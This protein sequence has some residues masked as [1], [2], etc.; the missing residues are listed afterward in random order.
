MLLKLNNCQWCVSIVHMCSPADCWRLI[1]R[2]CKQPLLLTHGWSRLELPELQKSVF[3]Y[4][5]PAVVL[6]L[7]H[8]NTY[9]E[10]GKCPG[11][12]HSLW[13]ETGPGGWARPPPFWVSWSQMI[14]PNYGINET[15]RLICV[16]EY[17]FDFIWIRIKLKNIAKLS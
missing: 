3:S 15:Q 1:V 10:K 5:N 2:L 14:N 12:R 16:S 8:Q 17:T 13:A 4:C 6:N 11:P 7:Y 9:R